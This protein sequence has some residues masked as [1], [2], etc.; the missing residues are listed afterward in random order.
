MCLNQTLFRSHVVSR[1]M[2][3]GYS[4]DDDVDLTEIDKSADG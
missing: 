2:A 4:A 3:Q 1:G